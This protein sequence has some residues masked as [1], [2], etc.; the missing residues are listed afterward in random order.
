MDISLIEGW[1]RDNKPASICVEAAH[2]YLDETPNGQ[3]SESARIGAEI[4]QKL[5][6]NGVLVTNQLFVDD[7]HPAKKTLDLKKYMDS[8]VKIGFTPDL[9]TFEKKMEL[10]AKNLLAILN[11]I[12]QRKNG[13][14]YLASSSNNILIMKEDAPTCSLLDAALY[15]AKISM[16]DLAITVLPKMYKGQ[17]KKV[18][19]ILRALGY[20][21]PPI[22]N[23]YFNGKEEII[24]GGILR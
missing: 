7:F 22:I 24:I 13:N 1:I 16:F 4:A 21:N 23:V 14:C 11:G 12:A 8:L 10:P 9:L 3:H 18:F 19:H 2:I 5:S 15:V 20:E 17:Q 6:G